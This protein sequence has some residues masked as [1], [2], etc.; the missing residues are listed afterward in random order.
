ML[1]ALE[2]VAAERVKADGW[3]MTNAQ[4]AQVLEAVHGVHRL[5]HLAWF[6][7]PHPEPYEAWRPEHIK[8]AAKAEAAKPLTGRQFITR[9]LGRR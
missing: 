9:L 8:A 5:M 1:E 4:L 3:T 7:E 2:T 6:Q